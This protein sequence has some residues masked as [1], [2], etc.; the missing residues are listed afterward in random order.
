MGRGVHVRR[1]R[2]REKE[3]D[4]WRNRERERNRQ[5]E[6]NRKTEGNG[7]RQAG[8]ERKVDPD[9]KKRE[10][11]LNKASQSGRGQGG[12]THLKGKATADSICW[13]DPASFNPTPF[14][15][16]FGIILATFIPPAFW[17]HPGRNTE[18]SLPVCLPHSPSWGWELFPRGGLG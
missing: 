8:T 18:W 15:S 5:G 2:R 14:P 17:L 9:R 10:S 3:T 1:G 4:T 11:C 7:E 13:I 12:P 6:R 16:G